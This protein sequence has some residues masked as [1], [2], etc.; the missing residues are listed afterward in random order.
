MKNINGTRVWDDI[1]RITELGDSLYNHYRAYVGN[2][3]KFYYRAIEG[4]PKYYMRGGLVRRRSLWEM[5]NRIRGTYTCGTDRVRKL[6]VIT[7]DYS[8]ARYG[9]RT[10]D[11][12]QEDLEEEAA[13]AMQQVTL[14]ELSWPYA[15]V[16]SAYGEPKLFTS[17]GENVAV[18]PYSVQPGIVRDL[19]YVVGGK[20]KGAWLQDLRDYIIDTVT[21]GPQGLVLRN[22]KYDESNLIPRKRQY[23]AS[24]GKGFKDW[25]PMPYM[26]RSDMFKYKWKL[27]R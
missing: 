6:D 3:R 26:S 14:D 20:E 25:Y 1:M 17:A 21:V 24:P 8:T 10:G 9:H 23:Y 18:N 22:W 12:D 5:Y 2:D 27:N 13:L 16:I 4:D 15:R 19:N 7:N 11:M